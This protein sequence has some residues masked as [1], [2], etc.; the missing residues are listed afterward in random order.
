M[1]IRFIETLKNQ[2]NDETWLSDIYKEFGSLAILSAVVNRR[3]FVKYSTS[4]YYPNLYLLFVGDSTSGKGTV[5]NNVIEKKISELDNTLI[6]P[7]RFTPEGLFSELYE[8]LIPDDDNNDDNDNR[9][10]NVVGESKGFIC[11]DELTSVVNKKD[12]MSDITGD[13]IE[14]YSSPHIYKKRL[15]KKSF[16][17]RN[18]FLSVI[19]GVQPN[20][21][22]DILN[23][24]NISSGFL[25]RFII[26]THKP[27]KR[28]PVYHNKFTSGYVDI[29]SEKLY[30]LFNTKIQYDDKHE[31]IYNLDN[32]LEMS[33]EPI[34]IDY[35]FTISDILNKLQK[36]VST[37]YNRVIDNIIKLSILYK[38]DELTPYLFTI[39]SNSTISHI[40]TNTISIKFDNYNNK[41]MQDVMNE[42]SSNYLINEYKTLLNITKN[43]ISSIQN[44]KQIQIKNNTDNSEDNNTTFSTMIMNDILI[45]PAIQSV[46]NKYIINKD[47]NNNLQFN[48]STL[49]IYTNNK[50]IPSHS[51][52]FNIQLHHVIRA[53]FMIFHDM[54]EKNILIG[55]ISGTD[56]NKL[57]NDVISNIIELYK[58]K[59]FVIYNNEVCI[60]TKELQL[61]VKYNIP[62]NYHYVIEMLQNS[63][64]ITDV[65]Q[66]IMPYP[67]NRAKYYSISKEFIDSINK[68]DAQ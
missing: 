18:V 25:S 4:T 46:L 66:G 21:L 53:S 60:N 67:L 43:A 34:A 65:L 27:Q 64:I 26:I 63:G 36:N 30:N 3:I 15:S 41:S 31:Y 47:T 28:K 40:N 55:N 33:I 8:K 2:L 32:Q 58:N 17:L 20:N 42:L 48:N 24:S 10:N 50:E 7:K 61:L 35:V 62:R 38:I 59:K 11:N 1:H 54:I 12:Y 57:Y 5:I 29:I 9:D 68:G 13:L 16:T 14:L 37:Y 52:N 49:F 39:N 56:F 51:I 45:K 19:L 44:N 23:K 6:M 22:P